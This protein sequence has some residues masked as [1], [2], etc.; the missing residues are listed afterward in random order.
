[1]RDSA[2]LIE[3][4]DDPVEVARCR[5]QDERARRNN[6]WLQSHWSDLLPRARGHYLVVAGEQAFIA[7]TPEAAWALAGQAH[8][9]DDGALGQYVFPGQGPR[10]YA[11]RRAVA[12]L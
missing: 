9:E 11:N 5:A 2:F 7:D 4:V 10:V 8:P 6:D 1:M 12:G 3:E